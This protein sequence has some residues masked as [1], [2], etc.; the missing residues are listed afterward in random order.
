[1]IKNTISLL[2]ILQAE[3]QKDIKKQE[4]LKY[5][6]FI[7]ENREKYNNKEVIANL[8]RVNNKKNIEKE[9]EK[10][11]KIIKSFFKQQPQRQE[12]KT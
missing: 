11:N 5:S 3:Q 10:K 12:I 4:A 9:I 7:E 1:M 8:I 6:R 2:K